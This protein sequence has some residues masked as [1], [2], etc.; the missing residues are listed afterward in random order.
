MGNH[1]WKSLDNPRQSVYDRAQPR[2][3]CKENME[4][5]AAPAGTNTGIDNRKIGI[6]LFLGSEVMFFSALIAAYLLPRVSAGKRA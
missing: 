6:W 4:A 5:H 1:S 2:G 3:S